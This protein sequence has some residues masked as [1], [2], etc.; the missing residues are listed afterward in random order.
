ME[1]MKSTMS[2]DQFMMHILNNLTLDYS[3]DI[4]KLE[5]RIGATSEPLEIEDMRDALSLTY[6]RISERFHS[7]DSDDEETALAAGQFK[8]R[9]NKCGKYRHKSA[10]C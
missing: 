3:M 1:V 6:E 10:D 9:C 5:D 2:D 7:N 4:S 8:G